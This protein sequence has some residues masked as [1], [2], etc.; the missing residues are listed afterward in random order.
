M[1]HPVHTKFTYIIILFQNIWSEQTH[2]V[3]VLY[4]VNIE[5]QMLDCRRRNFQTGV[6]ILGPIWVKSSEQNVAQNRTMAPKK[7]K[8]I[9]FLDLCA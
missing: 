3:T 6:N 4:Y 9:L 2:E 7:T 8:K 5:S 1:G